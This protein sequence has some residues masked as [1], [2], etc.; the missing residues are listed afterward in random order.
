MK[1]D[2]ARS[3]S[4]TVT[5]TAAILYLKLNHTAADVSS[6]F[7]EG[8]VNGD[9]P[10]GA[11]TGKY[12]ELR[13]RF[14]IRYYGDWSAPTYRWSGI[15]FV[16]AT[17]GEWICRL[18]Q[19]QQLDPRYWYQGSTATATFGSGSGQK[20]LSSTTGAAIYDFE[21]R[22]HTLCGERDVE[23]LMLSHLQ[24]RFKFGDVAGAGVVSDVML[25]YNA[26]W[27]RIYD[28]SA[29]FQSE[30]SKHYMTPLEL[31]E[32]HTR[33]RLA[34]MV[35]KAVAVDLVRSSMPTAQLVGSE[36]YQEW[37]DEVERFLTKPPELAGCEQ[38]GMG[39]GSI[40]LE[41]A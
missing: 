41:R 25:S 34:G 19:D 21:C 14:S 39:G 27:R 33:H 36:R 15:R 35:A 4:A 20:D 24:G 17:D 13:Q 16:C 12:R 30:L 37:K 10:W 26:L 11:A 29:R 23:E 28:Q 40:V 2:I 7:T 31:G 9:A 8:T 3:A 18:T 1:V 5:Q 32:E 22:L 38:V 6:M